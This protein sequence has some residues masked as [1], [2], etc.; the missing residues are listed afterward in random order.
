[1]NANERFEHMADAFRKA[2]GYM[3]PGKSTS[4]EEGGGIEMETIRRELWTAFCA[5]ARW[6]RV[7]DVLGGPDA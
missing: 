2:T 5:G 4:P 7:W 3:A 1:M 6:A